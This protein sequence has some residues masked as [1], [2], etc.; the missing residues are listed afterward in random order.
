MHTIHES[1]NNLSTKYVFMILKHL[2]CLIL[3]G[4]TWY[5][6]CIHG[7]I[8]RWKKWSQVRCD[9]IYAK[10]KRTLNLHTCFEYV[11]NSCTVICILSDTEILLRYTF[12]LLY[13]HSFYA[14]CSKIEYDLF[15]LSSEPSVSSNVSD[16]EKR[17]K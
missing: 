9:H 13:V 5:V 16:T 2:K 15:L 3:S 1:R 12:Y 8:V 6:F 11:L 14:L 4:K 17:L 7:K 10:K